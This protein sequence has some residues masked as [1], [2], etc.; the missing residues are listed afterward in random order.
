MLLI[1]FLTAYLKIAVKMQKRVKR[2]H[3]NLVV[4]RVIQKRDHSK[5]T[6]PI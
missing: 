2:H 3:Q 1:T 6:Q 5:S 4:K